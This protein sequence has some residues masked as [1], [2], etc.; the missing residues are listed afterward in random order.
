MRIKGRQP[1][2]TLLRQHLGKSEWSNKARLPLVTVYHISLSAETIDATG[3]HTWN[4]Y[5]NYTNYTN[6]IDL[7]LEA[8][9]ALEEPTLNLHKSR[10][11]DRCG[12]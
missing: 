12:C 6:Y 8:G 11:K 2:R 3:A 9:P 7:C 10:L 5:T 1:A 4:T